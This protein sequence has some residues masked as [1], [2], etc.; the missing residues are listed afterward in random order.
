VL[1]NDLQNINYDKNLFFG[2]LAVVYLAVGGALSFVLM[3]YKPEDNRIMK[4]TTIGI[5][6]GFVVYLI[7]FTLGLSFKGSGL[8][9]AVVDCGWQ[10]VEQATGAFIISFYYR[11][12]HRRE[13]LLAFA[14]PRD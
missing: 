9:Y 5:A 2:L 13:K 14:D 4:H 10:M 6:T 11:A 1:L 7:A 3:L 12:A 8:S